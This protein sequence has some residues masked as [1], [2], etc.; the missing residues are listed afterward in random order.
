[1]PYDNLKGYSINIISEIVINKAAVGVF[2]HK[3]AQYIFIKNMH[4]VLFLSKKILK[5]T[6]Y[7]SMYMH[8]PNLERD[9]VLNVREH[10]DY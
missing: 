8:T 5:Q 1:M 7:T 4:N 6:N 9:I 2:H 10:T 3:Y